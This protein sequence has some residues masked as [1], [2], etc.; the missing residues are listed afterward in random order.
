MFDG[1]HF[2]ELTRHERTRQRCGHRIAAVEQRPGLQRRH[3][4]VADEFLARVD[5]M[6]PRRAG[7]QRAIA[8]LL[9]IAAG[10]EVERQR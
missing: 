8:N 4:E 7:G 5:D 3:Y 9:E 1:S 6:R 10:A 2:G